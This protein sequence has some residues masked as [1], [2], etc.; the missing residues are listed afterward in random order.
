MPDFLIENQYMGS[1]IGIDEAGR[2]PLAGPVVAA[3]TLFLEQNIDFIQ[4]IN[5]SKKISVKKRQLIFNNIT[6]HPKIISAYAVISHQIID[7]INIFAA[8]KKAML[9][10]VNNLLVKTNITKDQLTILTDGKF[11]MLNG[12]FNEHPIIKGDSKSYSI[13]AASIIAKVIRDNLMQ[14]L[15]QKFPYYNWKNNA[16]YGT[17]EHIKAIFTHGISPHHRKS[18]APIKNL[19]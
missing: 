4:E 6:N 13:A 10:A 17:K 7:E 15:D 19:I 12:K 2:G 14:D 16:G 18:F 11:K 1:V 8:T 5:D 3:A 9:L